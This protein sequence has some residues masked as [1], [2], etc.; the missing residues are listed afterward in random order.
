ML[1]STSVNA[2]ADT[3]VSSRPLLPGPQDVLD[4]VTGVFSVLAGCQRKAIVKLEIRAICRRIHKRLDLQR[5]VALNS[6]IL[7]SV[8]WLPPLWFTRGI[9][10]GDDILGGRINQR[11][12]IDICNGSIS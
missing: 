6:E 2:L 4:E 8:L 9:E 12:D 1:Y 5:P 10:E 11:R 7:F 3:D